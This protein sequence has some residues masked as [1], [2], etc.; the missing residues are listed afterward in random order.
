MLAEVAVAGDVSVHPPLAGHDAEDAL[1]LVW[2]LDAVPVAGAVHVRS[3][4]PAVHA[5]AA[6]SDCGADGAVC[7]RVSG[8][9]S[10][11]AAVKMTMR[12]RHV[13]RARARKIRGGGHVWAIHR[14]GR[15]LLRFG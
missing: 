5:A 6:V 14:R 15:A 2:Y 7:A 3:T 8:A 13:P 12:V 4:W 11:Y 10:A 9:E 1:R